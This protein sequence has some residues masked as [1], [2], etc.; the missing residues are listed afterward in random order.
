MKVVIALISLI[1]TAHAAG[2]GV[3]HGSVSDLMWPAIN[4]ALL[5]S[6]LVWKV[7]KP[8]RE[9]FEKNANDVKFLFEHAEKKDKEAN[10]K[11]NALQEKMGNLSSEK[12][13]ITQ[14]AEK[15]ANDFISKSEKESQEYLRR[16]EVDSV[17]K[18][19]H[20]KVSRVAALE[21]DLID[22]VIAKA[23]TKIGKDSGLSEKVT[24]KLIS[25]V[26]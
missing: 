12:N 24:K 13:K 6:F 17:N 23:K 14:N 25:Q 10:I 9:M 26:R 1:G 5:A 7:K 11:L 2:S 21:E 20:E 18:I 4:F 16:L 22:E 19:E 15:E 3:G 8:L